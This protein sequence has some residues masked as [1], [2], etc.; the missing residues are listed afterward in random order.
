MITGE[1]I[2]HNSNSGYVES[3]RR[4][5]PQA[6]SHFTFQA[7][8][9]RLI[10]V[11]IQGV[12]DLYTDPQVHTLEGTGY[13]EGN[14][15]ANGFALFFSGHRCSPLCA[16]LGLVPLPK[17]ETELFRDDRAASA[18]ALASETSGAHSSS[19]GSSATVQVRT[20][21]SAD[22]A[23]MPET[24]G[25]DEHGVA[26]ALRAARCAL[27]ASVGT[28]AARE[29]ARRTWAAREAAR[30]ITVVPLEALPAWAL[31]AR[32]WALEELPVAAEHRAALLRRRSVGAL[33]RQRPPADG[34]IAT[35][36]VWLMFA[37]V[38]LALARYCACGGL[39]V[40]DGVPDEPSAVFHVCFAARGGHS[41]AL[42]AWR[43]LARGVVQDLVPGV[44]LGRELPD[45][46]RAL[47]AVLA[48]DGDLAACVELADAAA[49]ADEKLS[50]LDRALA[51]FDGADGVPLVGLERH[52]LLEKAGRARLAAGDASGAAEAFSEASEAALALGKG[53]LSVKLASLAE[54]AQARADGAGD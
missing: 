21:R 45:V 8:R 26:A 40:L 3:H 19:S 50:W 4:A 44:Q 12:A 24:T 6:F 1:Y 48:H 30:W 27:T 18:V 25:K 16:K 51:A 9:G 31:E 54:E 14:L 20:W 33:A 10:I 5:T 46:A 34:L 29:S 2:K 53:K 41:D 32:S 17:S 42:R 13:G 49:N 38:H 36:E 47:T 11:D 37:P 39:P 52:A 43:D 23:L 15:G 7:S 22:A 28:H 35:H